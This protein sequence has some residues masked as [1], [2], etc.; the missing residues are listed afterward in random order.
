[1]I[2]NKDPFIKKFNELDALCREKR[3]KSISI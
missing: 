2:A 3:D 1:M